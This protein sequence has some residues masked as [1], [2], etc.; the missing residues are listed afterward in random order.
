M[1]LVGLEP[2]IPEIKRLQTNAS[3]GAATGIGGK[4]PY[5]IEFQM[6]SCFGLIDYHH[7]N[8]NI[9]RVPRCYF[10]GKETEP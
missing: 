2:A 6:G 4:T 7:R 3:D 8:K 1:H 9:L 10:T 5:G